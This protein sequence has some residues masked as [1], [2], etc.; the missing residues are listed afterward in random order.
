M[1]RKGAYIV[2]GINHYSYD[3]CI[4]TTTPDGRTIGNLTKYSKT[5]S[6]HQTYARVNSC[7]IHL[8]EVP[9]GSSSLD[10]LELAGVISRKS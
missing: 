10:L 1:T 4:C 6:K 9:I 3:T 2:L 5:T 8:T 7:D